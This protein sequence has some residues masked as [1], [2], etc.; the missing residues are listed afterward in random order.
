MAAVYYLDKQ[1]VPTHIPI[2]E[3]KSQPTTGDFIS[4]LRDMRPCLSLRISNYLMAKLI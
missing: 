2:T 4:I 1:V 3:I